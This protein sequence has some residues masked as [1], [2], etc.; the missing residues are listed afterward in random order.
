MH[1][2]KQN[3]VKSAAAGASCASSGG[4]VEGVVFAV[5]RRIRKVEVE[6]GLYPRA[7]RYLHIDF[8]GAVVFV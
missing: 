4:G 7:R 5:E 6:I 2:R 8:A 1:V 3:R